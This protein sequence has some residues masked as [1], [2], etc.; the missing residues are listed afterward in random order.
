M[1]IAYNTS[2]VT[3]NLVFALDAGNTRSYSGSG[4]TAYGLTNGSACNFSSSIGF[5][6]RG[7]GG[8]VFDGTFKYI[9]LPTT[10]DTN[11][12]F[13]INFWNRRNVINATNTLLH[14]INLTSY[15]QI[16]YNPSNAVQLV[17]SNL[18]DVGSFTGY[19]STAGNDVYLTVRLTKSTNT[20]DLYINGS[21]ISS[22]A[23]TQT[24]VTSGPIIGG[25]YSFAAEHFNGNV[26]SLSYY[27]RALSA[28]EIAQNFNATRDRYGI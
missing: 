20:Y 26:Y 5:T 2:I 6:T 24:Y 28:Q 23:S 25:G 12:D 13:T 7:N 3:D 16:R 19:T 11:N 17:K 27:N 14:G 10:I 22:I 15:L 9:T 18:S 1:G 8:L 21:Y 4:L